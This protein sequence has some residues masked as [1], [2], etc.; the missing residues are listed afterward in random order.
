MSLPIETNVFTLN[1]LYQLVVEGQ[2][3][4]TDRSQ[5]GTLWSWGRNCVGQVGDNTFE[6]RSSPVQV[7]GTAW[8]SVSSGRCHGLAR[9]TDNTLWAWGSNYRGQLARSINDSFPSPVQIPGTT[10]T[11]ISAGGEHSIARKS[12]NTLWVW[13]SNICGEIGNNSFP[14]PSIRFT[15]PIQ[16]PGTTWVE[17]CGGAQVSMARQ[18]D[19]TLWMWGDNCFGQLGIGNVTYQR[20]PNQIPGTSWVAITTGG[21]HSLARKSD[22]TLWSWG[23]NQG[24]QLG[25]MSFICRSSPVQVS[26][27]SWIDVEASKV[28]FVSP[29]TMARK[30]DGTLWVWGNNSQGQLG[31]NS[32]YPS[33]IGSPIQIPG[34]AWID[35]AASASASFARKTNNT[36]WVWGGSFFQSGVLGLNDTTNRSSPVQLPGTSWIEIA[37][38][39]E[40][41]ALAR[42]S[43]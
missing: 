26:G 29:H 38:G 24:G 13:G 15:S 39:N 20:F 11:E 2:V 10:W 8:L 17:I 27:T 12:D 14:G 19:G 35:I 7:P 6:D 36:L 16:I 9:K 37:G 18:S 5:P 21:N 25:D 43:L 34:N 33:G 23:Q 28:G 40:N 22:G 1:K 32:T 42:K 31:Q 4:Y 41:N 30:S 3:G